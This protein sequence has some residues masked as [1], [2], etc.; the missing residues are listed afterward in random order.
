MVIYHLLDLNEYP[1]IPN[2]PEIGRCVYR[3]EV[4]TIDAID[5][6]SILSWCLNRFISLSLLAIK[7]PETVLS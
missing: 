2:K 5:N 6:V 4:K 7:L 1:W 3:E